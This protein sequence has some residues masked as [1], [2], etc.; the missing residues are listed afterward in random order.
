RNAV[1]A[2]PKASLLVLRDAWPLIAHPKAPLLTLLL[3][4][5]HHQV[6]FARVFQGI[7]QQVCHDLSESL[8]IAPDRHWSIPGSS[9]QYRPLWSQVA[10]VLHGLGNDRSQIAGL[11]VVLQPTMADA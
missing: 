3:Y 6:L 2:L 9:K 5:C 1:K 10:L 11:H 7:R 8:R 4:P